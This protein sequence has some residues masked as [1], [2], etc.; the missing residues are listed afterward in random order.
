MDLKHAKIYKIK[1]YV[2]S[3]DPDCKLGNCVLFHGTSRKNS[4]KILKEGYKN[5]T[6]GYF[7]RGVYMTESI[8]YAA[9]Y[10]IRKAGVTAKKLSKPTCVKKSMKIYIFVNEVAE[11]RSLKVEKYEN[12]DILSNRNYAFPKHPFCKHMHKNSPDNKMKIDADGRFNSGE[13]ISGLSL[14]N[15]YVADWNLIKPKFL[16]KIESSGFNYKKYRS[17]MEYL[18]ENLL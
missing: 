5:S 18:V 14:Q 4:R 15:E 1:S 17:F 3:S 6:G 16:I 11:P 10:S 12:Y 9:H 7:G 13:K 8:D 2:E